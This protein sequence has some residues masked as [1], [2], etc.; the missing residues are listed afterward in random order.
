MCLAKSLRC[1]RSLKMV[2]IGR[3]QAST[4]SSRVKRPTTTPFDKVGRKN[5][6]SSEY[7]GQW[8]SKVCELTFVREPIRRT[9]TD[10]SLTRQ[11]RLPGYKVGFPRITRN[12]QNKSESVSGAVHLF[13]QCPL[14]GLLWSI[15][16]LLQCGRVI[17]ITSTLMHLKQ[18]AEQVLCD[19]RLGPPRGG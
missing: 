5:P 17:L 7:G 4:T 11:T 8:S 18:S 1:S 12:G 3:W 19:R 16:Y 14:Y 6:C 2:Y 13:G 10:A 9:H 15:I